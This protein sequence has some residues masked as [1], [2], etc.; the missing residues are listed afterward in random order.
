M[1]HLDHHPEH[2]IDE[3]ICFQASPKKNQDPI[4]WTR[5][6][7]NVGW[8]IYLKEPA[9]VFFMIMKC[10]VAFSLGLIFGVCWTYYHR[11]DQKSF[12]WAVVAWIT[13]L[14]GV[15]EI[16]EW[17]KDNFASPTLPGKEKVA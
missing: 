12:P 13:L 16:S 2:A 4:F 15:F 5:G 7:V 3:L 11:D 1:K 9:K 14:S 6:Q 10:S 8:G 17:L